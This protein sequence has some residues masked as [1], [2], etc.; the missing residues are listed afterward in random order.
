MTLTL[1]WDGGQKAVMF[2]PGAK[3]LVAAFCIFALGLFGIGALALALLAGVGVMLWNAG[4]LVLHLC[5]A[6][7]ANDWLVQGLALL[8]VGVL[9][10][11]SIVFFARSIMTMLAKPVQS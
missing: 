5:S 1:T 9:L 6:V 8:V 2:Q 3:L 7:F 11:W 10:C 4:T